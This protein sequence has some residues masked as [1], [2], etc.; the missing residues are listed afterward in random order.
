MI[1][2]QKQ[3]K[4][5]VKHTIIQIPDELWDEISIILPKEKPAKTVG[6]PT[7]SF[8]KVFDGIM[9]VLKTGCQ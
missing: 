6:R 9:Y 1:H 7:V 5:M 8:R 4:K 2:I 3:K